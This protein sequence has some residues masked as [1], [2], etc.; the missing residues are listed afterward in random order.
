MRGT[1]GI[2][3]LAR[4]NCKIPW[5]KVRIIE[6]YTQLLKGPTT[7]IRTARKRFTGLIHY[8]AH[9]GKQ[10]KN[11]FLF[12]VAEFGLFHFILSHKISNFEVIY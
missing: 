5:E 1:R 7:E 11:H 6:Y 3:N 2:Y 10:K 12:I 4:E 9:H 8:Y